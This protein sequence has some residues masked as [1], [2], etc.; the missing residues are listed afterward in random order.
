MK[1]TFKEKVYTIV[2]TKT[3]DTC[4]RCKSAFSELHL[5]LSL[6]WIIFSW[7]IWSSRPRYWYYKYCN[8][9]NTGI[10]S[11]IIFTI[12]EIHCTILEIP[13]L[14]CYLTGNPVSYI[15]NTGCTSIVHLQYWNTRIVDLCTIPE[16]PVFFIHQ[17]W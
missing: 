6:L 10:T 11:I 14:Y 17:Y 9:Y 13:V 1:R 8:I 7:I 3:T 12:L 15:Y 16:A 5:F 4:M 2:K